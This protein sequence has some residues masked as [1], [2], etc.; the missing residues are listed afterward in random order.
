[1]RRSAPLAVTI[2]GYRFNSCSIWRANQQGLAIGLRGVVAIFARPLRANRDA[3]TA[4]TLP[5]HT[6]AT[7]RS[8]P[9]RCIMPE[10]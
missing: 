4:P 2:R 7:G 10:P 5:E 6:I 1:M 8:K 9:G 3:S